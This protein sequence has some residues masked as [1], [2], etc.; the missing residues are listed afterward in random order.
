MVR[1]RRNDALASE[2]GANSVVIVYCTAIRIA[3]I[4]VLCGE[5]K[6]SFQ[7]FYP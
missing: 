6:V 2:N 4:V 7:I 5:K 3:E 1:S